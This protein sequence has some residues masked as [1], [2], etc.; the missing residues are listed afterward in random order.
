[1]DIN[2]D[3]MQI[4]LIAGSKGTHMNIACLGSREEFTINVLTRRPE[5]FASKEVTAVY[6][7]EPGKKTTG[8]INKV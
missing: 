1:M 7:S 3:K 6:E 4:C 5:I 8:K 2:I